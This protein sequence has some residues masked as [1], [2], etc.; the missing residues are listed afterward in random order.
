MNMQEIN[1]YI[2]PTVL[3][4]CLCAGYAI[5]HLIPSEGARRFIPMIVG[6]LGILISVWNAHWTFSPDTV[7]VG[8]V[9][10]LASTGMHQSFAQLISGRG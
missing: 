1:T 3:I 2:V 4:C 8:L 6:L 10:G 7:L 5:K 9:S